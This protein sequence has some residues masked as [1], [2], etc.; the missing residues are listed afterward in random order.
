VVKK[1]R[2]YTFDEVYL[3][4]RFIFQGIV[5]KIHLDS[6]NSARSQL[7][8][9]NPTCVQMSYSKLHGCSG[10]T[11]WNIPLYRHMSNE[12]LRCPNKPQMLGLLLRVLNC[13][14]AQKEIPGLN[15]SSKQALNSTIS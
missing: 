15:F 9:E 3:I 10:M 14:F 4:V 11:L 7:G 8:Q 5:K 6:R 2:E 13:E 1:K 12:T